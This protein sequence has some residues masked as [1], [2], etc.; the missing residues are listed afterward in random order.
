[1]KKSCLIVGLVILLVVVV[2]GKTF[3]AG[4]ELALGAWEQSPRGELSF[5]ELTDFDILDLEDDLGYDDETRLFA[6]LK[7]DM[8]TVFPN[9]YLMVT[10]MGFDGDGRKDVDFKFGDVTFQGN[11]DFFSE[12]ILDHADLALY[13]GLPFVETATAEKLNIELGINIR[14]YDFEGTIEQDAT[15]LRES[16]SF[17]APVPMVYL[18]AQLRLLEK[19]AIEAEARGLVLGDDKGYSLIG[20]LKWK[21]F[22]PLFIAG[23]YRTD[24]ID[25]EEDDFKL[26]IDFSGVFGEAGVVF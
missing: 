21:L 3:C 11:V 2:P 1:M 9:I 7:I 13:Y 22:G 15:G 18:G 8:P 23:G 20:R 24:R 12:I 25:I 6:R 14:V 4:V 17:T 16:E 26:D 10:P 5:E 19:L